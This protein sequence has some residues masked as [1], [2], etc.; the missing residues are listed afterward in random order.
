MTRKAWLIARM[1][2]H[3]LRSNPLIHLVS[4]AVITAAF[5][6]LGVFLLAA[7]NLRALAQHCEEKI[8]VCVYLKDGLPDDTRRE[9]RKKLSQMA[10]VRSVEY[11]SKDQ[12]MADFKKML[13]GKADLLEGLSDNP[14]PASFTLSLSPGQR[15]LSAVDELARKLGSWQGVSEVDYGASMLE[16]MSSAAGMARAGVFMVGA[17]VLLA[18]VFIISNTIKLTMY[19]RS[20]EIGI[21][22]LVGADNFVVRMPFVLEGIIQGGAAAATGAALLWIMFSLAAGETALPGLFA[23]FTPVFLSGPVV[24]TMVGTGALMGAAGSMSRVGQYLKV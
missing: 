6:T 3:D 22:K 21:M 1:A 19:A 5:L 9:Y 2:G 10:A 17:L 4:G 20:E 15:N 7:A 14:L 23:G 12:A 13:G 8:E 11:V 16:H 24:W 18:V